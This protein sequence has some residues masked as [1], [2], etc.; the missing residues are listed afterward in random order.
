MTAWDTLSLPLPV[1]VRIFLSKCHVVHFKFTKLVLIQQQK[2]CCKFCIYIHSVKKKKFKTWHNTHFHDL[3]YFV[4]TAS[5]WKNVSF[6]LINHF[7]N[8][9]WHMQCRRKDLFWFYKLLTRVDP[10]IRDAKKILQGHAV[11]ESP[12]TPQTEA[13]TGTKLL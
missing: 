10:I 13:V 7:F 1:S 6:I 2:S 4:S 9:T 5:A 11:R 12:W 3:S 8:L